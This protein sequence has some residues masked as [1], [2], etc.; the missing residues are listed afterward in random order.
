MSRGLAGA[1]RREGERPHWRKLVEV[2]VTRGRGDSQVVQARELR[3]GDYIVA[4][5][6]TVLA[7]QEQDGNT[8]KVSATSS[9]GL[10]HQTS[11]PTDALVEVIRG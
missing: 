6:L 8:L 1:T 10:V 3:P 5:E 2:T 7:T 11:F 4:G 9:G